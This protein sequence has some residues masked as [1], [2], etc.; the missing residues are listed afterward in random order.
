MS[1]LPGDVK[2][3]GSESLKPK[4][5]VLLVE[6]DE[7]DYL[8]TRDLLKEVRGAGCELEWVRTYDRALGVMKRNE[9]D[10][11]LLDVRLGQRDGLELLR[12]SIAAGCRAPII[13][14]TGHADHDIDMEAMIAGAADFLVKGELAAP[15]LDRS[16]RYAL[17]RKKTQDLLRRSERRLQRQNRALV[18]LASSKTLDGG[19]FPHALS[20]IT[21]TTARTLEV[22]RVTVWICDSECRTLRAADRFD[23]SALTHSEGEEFH[24]T[25]YPDYL[26]ALEHERILAAEEVRADPRTRQLYPPGH[27]DAITS[28]LDAT[29][30]SGGKLTGLVSHEHTGPP[31]HWASEE[32]NFAGSIADLV[33]LTLE[34][35]ERRRA[36]EGR[37]QLIQQLQEALANI[38]TLSG[39]IPI[40]A[41]CKKIRDD[42]GFWNQLEAYVQRYSEARF[43]HG[44]CPECEARFYQEFGKEKS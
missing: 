35:R 8:I 37:E 4:V 16:I 29:I 34:A 31:H 33:S 18:E 23:G 5:K 12:E 10:V 11:Y 3:S 13:L 7:D 1:L 19:D 22:S 21:E 27:D 28:R 44:I 9:H 42:S 6:D 32:Q 17:E 41:C 25:D 15:L 24:L 26:K 20:E 39:L 40:C 14:L 2:R 38:K 36:E 43:S 30:R